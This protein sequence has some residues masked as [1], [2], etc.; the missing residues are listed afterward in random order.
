MT[1]EQVGAILGVDT[2]TVKV[3]VHRA[4][5][6]LRDAFSRVAEGE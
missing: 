5:K 2:G 3:R 6:E 1:H 4:I